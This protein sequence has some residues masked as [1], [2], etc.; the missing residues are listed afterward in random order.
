[1]NVKKNKSN[2]NR[3]SKWIGMKTRFQNAIH[4]RFV[5]CTIW[6]N[7]VMMHWQRPRRQQHSAARASERSQNNK[8]L[9]MSND[10]HRRMHTRAMAIQ[11]RKRDVPSQRKQCLCSE[12]AECALCEPD[13][14]APFFCAIEWTQTFLGKI[15]YEFEF[16]AVS[17]RWLVLSSFGGAQ[18]MRDGDAPHATAANQYHFEL[19]RCERRFQSMHLWKEPSNLNF[20]GK[21]N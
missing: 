4:F 9:V 14:H 3:N 1:M 11:W 8:N 18:R 17:C 16:G 15:H 5:L 10:W 12:S 21:I 19:I 13:V 20:D 6:F 2:A 7:F